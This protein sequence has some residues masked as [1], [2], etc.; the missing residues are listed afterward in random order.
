M[1]RKKKLKQELDILQSKIEIHNKKFN[2]DNFSGL[3][4][5]RK[6]NSHSWF[7]IKKVF[8]QSDCH[9]ILPNADPNP[10]K[11]LMNSKQ[12][13][14]LPNDKQKKTMLE[15]LETFRLMYNE[16]VKMIRILKKEG[17]K[18]FI[19]WQYIR[20]HKMKEIK[21]KYVN[22]YKIPVHILDKAIKLVCSNWKSAL[23]NL[24][25]GYI[26]HFTIRYIKQSKPKKIFQLE[27]GMFSKNGFCVTVLGDIMK[28]NEDFDYKTIKHDCTVCYDV[29]KDRFL[30]HIPYY[31]ERKIVDN[32]KSVVGIDPGLK[33]FLTCVS[34]ERIVK[35]G[36]N[37]IDQFRPQFERID[38]LNKFNNK[39]SKRLVRII[40]TRMKNQII[41]L[42]WK[43]I[44][45][46]VAK[47]NI[48]G[49]IIGN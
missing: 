48:G 34:D 2:Y 23:T 10:K 28:N 38:Y 4:T 9:L 18:K 17:N 44:N 22:K 36:N 35:I 40:Y 33:T 6:G 7:D 13:V 19:N 37:V 31:A 43:S 5:R 16:T 41:D 20:T 8:Y 3:D 42:H 26:R 27:K 21:Q 39:R 29:Y 45:Y 25:N 11:K 46:L 14:L 49:I 47:K 1:K 15:W 12:I 32:K 30:L 24:K